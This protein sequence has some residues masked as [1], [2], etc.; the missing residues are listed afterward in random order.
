MERRLRERERFCQPGAV[1]AT[2]PVPLSGV[3][4]V[5]DRA[6]VLDLLADLQA[7]S[8]PAHMFARLFDA[9]EHVKESA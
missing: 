7:S 5:S 9:P 4:G 6:Q 1:Q 8:G 2:T 3:L